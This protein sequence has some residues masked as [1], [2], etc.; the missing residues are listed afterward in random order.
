MP[1][2]GTLAS[3][4]RRGLAAPLNKRKRAVYGYLSLSAS[5]HPGA[6][7]ILNIISPPLTGLRL[8]AASHSITKQEHVEP[9]RAAAASAT[10]LPAVLG[11]ELRREEAAVIPCQDEIAQVAAVLALADAVRAGRADVGLE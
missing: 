7:L 1:T 2:V 6:S 3:P 11:L 4:V 10:S 5:A 9:T 8:G